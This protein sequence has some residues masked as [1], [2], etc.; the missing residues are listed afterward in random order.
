MNIHSPGRRRRASLTIRPD[1]LEAARARGINLSEAAE[2]GIGAA[3]READAA[4]W[5]EENR[6]AMEGYNRYI[7]EHG[8]PLEKY[9]L[10]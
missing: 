10:F 8:L 6:E 7:A 2:R 1:Y 3:I 9:R 5:L 4:A